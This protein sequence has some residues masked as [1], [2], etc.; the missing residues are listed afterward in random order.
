[1]FSK[2]EE[3]AIRLQF[4]ST[5]EK[6]M[7][8][9]KGVHGNKVSWM[10]FNTKIKPLYFRMEADNVGARL[11]I[12]I[13]FNDDGIREL[14][15]EQFTE[16]ENL[17]SERFES[18]LNWYANFEHSNGKTISRIA[19][20]KTG[21]KLYNREDWPIMH[22]FLIDQFVRLESFWAEFGEVFL[23]LKN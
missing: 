22:D 7:E 23:N 20:E 1:M 14:F 15:Y 11:C 9:I 19:I 6:R 13:Q 3:K 2:E 5:L 18:Q 10:S 21:V 4:W 8:S 16:F 17:L 12:D